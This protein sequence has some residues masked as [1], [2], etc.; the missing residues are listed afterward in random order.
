MISD[1]EHLFSCT[2]WPS[3]CLWRNVCLGLLP[4]FGLGCLFW[5][6][7]ASWVVCIFW[8]L[9]PSGSIICQYFLPI[10]RCLCFL[11][12]AQDFK[13]SRSHLFIF[14]FISILLGD[15]KD[16]GVI[17]GVVCLYFPVGGLQCL[18][19][20]LGLQSIMSL[21]LCIM[22]NNDLI[23]FTHSY[24]AFPEPFV[25]ETVILTLCSIAVFVK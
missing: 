23:S 4:I 11:C 15:K 1:V 12:C 25:Q 5:W 3:M 8:R 21:F 18:V 17:C 9:I 13:L 6:C 14:V 10:W 16:L 22:L 2:F 19:S 7:W 20:H 24:T